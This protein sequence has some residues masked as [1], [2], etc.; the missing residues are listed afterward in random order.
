MRAMKPS[1]EPALDGGSVADFRQRLLQ[2]IA[3][4]TVADLARE[5]GVS[6]ADLANWSRIV[7][8]AEKVAASFEEKLVRARRV[9]ELEE[10][11]EELRRVVGKQGVVLGILEKKG[12]VSSRNDP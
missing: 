8:R 5:N 12:I 4:K 11:I 10:E 7:E 1:T 2:K 3:D 6:P 9:R